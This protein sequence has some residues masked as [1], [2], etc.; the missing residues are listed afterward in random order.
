M[1]DPALSLQRIADDLLDASRDPIPERQRSLL[2][3]LSLFHAALSRMTTSRLYCG[4]NRY[5]DSA[6]VF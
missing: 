4:S 1:P 5:Y 2:D 3:I 6:G